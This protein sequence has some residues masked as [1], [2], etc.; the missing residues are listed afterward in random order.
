MIIVTRPSPDGSKLVSQLT[1]AG[2]DACHMPLFTILPCPKPTFLQSQLN[3]LSPGDIVMALS[4]RVITSLKA[5][6]ESILFPDHVN[7]VAI[8]QKTAAVFQELTKMPVIYPKKEESSEGLLALPLFNTV[9]QKRILILRG[10]QGR[11]WLADNLKHRGGI[12]SYM[13]CYKRIPINYS[14]DNTLNWPKNTIIILTSTESLYYLNALIARPRRHHF[15]LLVCSERITK[16]ATQFYW[17]NVILSK[18][19]NNQ[20]LFKTILTLCHNDDKIC[21]ISKMRDNHD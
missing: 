3:I 13:E 20:I 11:E 18:S 4:P 14:A 10:N 2:F 9:L 17:S 5:S 7:Y 15:I 12:I 16:K 1:S 8:G 19:A 21:K 6:S